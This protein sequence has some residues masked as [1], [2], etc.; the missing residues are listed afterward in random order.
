MR[1]RPIVYFELITIK[2]ITHTFPGK[3]DISSRYTKILTSSLQAWDATFL[4][5]SNYLNS[6]TAIDVLKHHERTLH[7]ILSPACSLLG[8]YDVL[9]TRANI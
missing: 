1:A 8:I 6:F 4:K 2:L 5:W 9:Q 7:R 3:P